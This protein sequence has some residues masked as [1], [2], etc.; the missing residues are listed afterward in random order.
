MAV[1]LDSTVV[2]LTEPFLE[3]L[4]DSEAFEAFAEIG[5]A[6]GAI[7]LLFLLGHDFMKILEGGKFDI[8]ML[9]PV[10]IFLF[11]NNF[12][13]V[14]KPVLSFTGEI[15]KTCIEACHEKR[16][17]IIRN[18]GGEDADNLIDLFL[19]L[20]PPER[21]IDSSLIDPLAA[22]SRGQE[23]DSEGDGSG[24]NNGSTQEHDENWIS[25]GISK[26]WEG[27]KVKLLTALNFCD[28]YSPLKVITM[29]LTGLLCFL[30]CFIIQILKFVLSVLAVVM[31]GIIV[32]FGP[33]TFAFAM[34]PGRLGNIKSWFI[35]L[36]QFALY[37]PI[38]DVIS[39]FIL[40]ATCILMIDC[41][42]DSVALLLALLLANVVCLT[43]VPSIASMII[44]GASGSIALVAGMKTI[45]DGLGMAGSS[46]GAAMTV[47]KHI[48]GAGQ[49]ISLAQAGG[50]ALK[51][52]AIDAVTGNG[53][54]ASVPSG[55]GPR[56][57]GSP[58]GRSSAPSGRSG[59]R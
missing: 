6:I 52:K 25:R 57:G 48:P 39:L 5:V 19:T 17:S 56:S 9:L 22:T 36:C 13:V 24:I 37:A 54:D 32:I 49:L 27:L 1:F 35:R 31:T 44:E 38:C 10:L 23:Y 21:Q 14:Y 53:G 47:A 33:I 8:S 3:A 20:R 45:V 51:Q 4:Q 28:R 50:A 15:T 7:F 34:F 58:S 46:A 30:L 41:T 40:Q 42:F 12:R 16:A 18:V 2:N 26:F 11:I 59:R 29:G 43:A 55:R